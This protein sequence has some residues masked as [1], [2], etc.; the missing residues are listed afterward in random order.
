MNKNKITVLGSGNTGISTAAKLSHDG[1]EI[2]LAEIP[3]FESS[4]LD[5]KENKTILLKNKS[6]EVKTSI[7]DVTPIPHNGCR[8]PKRR[9]V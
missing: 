4:I 5:I 8:P 2:I 3:E 1:F 6:T 9:R 7:K